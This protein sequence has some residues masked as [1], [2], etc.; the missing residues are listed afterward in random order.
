V[1]VCLCVF[2]CVCRVCVRYIM[3]DYR[4]IRRMYLC[5]ASSTAT[6]TWAKCVFAYDNI[7]LQT[8]LCYFSL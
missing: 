2:V 3:Y 7:V 6:R 5:V 8:L 1:C 4:T